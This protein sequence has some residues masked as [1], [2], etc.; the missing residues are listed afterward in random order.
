MFSIC[1]CTREGA[2]N[3]AMNYA[4]KGCATQ[5]RN[6]LKV[7]GTSFS[8]AGS[9]VTTAHLTREISVSARFKIQKKQNK[10]GGTKIITY[11]APVV[12]RLDNAIH[13]IN[14]YPAD[15]C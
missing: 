4:L 3:G 5:M 11:Q 15:K 8:D 13:R 10:Y 2:L 9:L 1:A 12:Q 14:H 7:D 6:Y